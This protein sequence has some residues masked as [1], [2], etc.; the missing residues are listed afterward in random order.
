MLEEY[1]GKLS[2]LDKEY[3]ITDQLSKMSRQE[4]WDLY[5]GLLSTHTTEPYMD[6]PQ[7]YY[8]DLKTYVNNM[9]SDTPLQLEELGKIGYRIKTRVRPSRTVY[10]KLRGYTETFYPSLR[11]DLSN[12]LQTSIRTT[13]PHIAEMNKVYHEYRTRTRVKRLRHAVLPTTNNTLH[14]YRYY[15]DEVNR[16]YRNF[17][18]VFDSYS[19]TIQETLRVLSTRLGVDVGVE[20][21]S[22][23]TYTLHAREL[24]KDV[25]TISYNEDYVY[26]LLKQGY[27]VEKIEGNPTTGEDSHTLITKGTETYKIYR[28]RLAL[29][30]GNLDHVWRLLVPPL[31]TTKY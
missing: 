10:S 22:T 26:E 19:E 1:M 30:N 16:N 27:A 9:L 5:K 20:E 4:K 28:D 23:L 6:F 17:L 2:E 13:R 25:V 12:S 29:T 7:S 15:A 24:K 31:H 11:H 3:N 21:V 8:D 14:S 18:K